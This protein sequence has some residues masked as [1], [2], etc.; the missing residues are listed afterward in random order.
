MASVVWLAGCAATV[1]K[2]GAG[3]V[4]TPL[5]ADAPSLYTVKQGDTLF[6]I[7]KANGVSVRDVAAWNNIEDPA[8]IKVGQPLRL[9]PP[10]GVVETMRP[11]RLA[12]SITRAAMLTSTPSQSEPMR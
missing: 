3:V 2:P 5:G 11:P 7:A 12:R 4:V 9:T 1:A 6:S 10:G 8:N